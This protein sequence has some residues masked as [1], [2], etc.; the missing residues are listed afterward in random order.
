[1]AGFS[2]N[3]VQTSGS[4]ITVLLVRSEILPALRLTVVEL[5]NET[6]PKLKRDFISLF[7]PRTSYCVFIACHRTNFSHHKTFEVLTGVS[8]MLV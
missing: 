2:N 7:P 6:T 3:S 1:M 8:T 5:K 4:V